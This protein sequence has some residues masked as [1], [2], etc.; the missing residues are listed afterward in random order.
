MSFDNQSAAQRLAMCNDIGE[1]AYVDSLIAAAMVDTLRS[2]PTGDAI[3]QRL[4][5]RYGVNP[6]VSC[7]PKCTLPFNC[8]KAHPPR[9]LSP[10]S[11]LLTRKCAYNLSEHHFSEANL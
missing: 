8:I 3:M 9:L 10:N 2:L 1:A 7:P 5:D 6:E 4:N 11:D